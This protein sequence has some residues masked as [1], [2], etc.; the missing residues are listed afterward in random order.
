MEKIK[1]DKIKYNI[2]E[3]LSLLQRFFPNF[4]CYSKYETENRK[5][6]TQEG[7]NENKF[8]KRER[9]SA[10]E[11]KNERECMRKKEREGVG[12]RV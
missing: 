12:E 9:E 4:L 5:R 6:K 8:L 1:Y 2:F 10:R 11:R 7:K 3:T